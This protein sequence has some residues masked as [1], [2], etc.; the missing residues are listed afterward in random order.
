MD[1]WLKPKKEIALERKHPWIF[2]GALAH[3]HE[4]PEDGT[5]VR[6][7]DSKGNY[8]A[9]GHYHR[10]SIAVR[11]LSYQ[12]EN[13]SNIDFWKTAIQDAWDCRKLVGL[14]DGKST[15]SFRL[16]HGEGD[17]LSGLVVDVYGS[18][19][20]LQ[21]HSIGMYLQKELI[22]QA[23]METS[24]KRIE[25]IYDKSKEA[26][27]RAFSAGL[28]DG[29]IVGAG[30]GECTISENNHSFKINLETGQKTGFFLDQRDNRALLAKYAAGKS[31]LNTFCYTGGFSV[32]AFRAGASSVISVDVSSKAMLI[33]DENIKLNAAVA[34]NHISV[35][36]DAMS[37]FKENETLFDIVVVDPPAFAKSMNKRHNAVQGYKRLNAAAIKCI[38]PG[39][40]LFTFSCSQVVDRELFY[41]TITAAA[42][43]SGRSARVLHHMGQG[44]DHPVSLFHPEGH[45]LKG[46]VVRV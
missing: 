13:L 45:Y 23:I 36:Q 9:S 39:G 12:D 42:I 1:I 17:N 20:V 2:S 34:S 3:M 33:T 46:L 11:I 41:N 30:S 4:E 35:T 38:K 22:A 16:I 21:C 24:N 19:A 40:L 44:A 7:C 32:Y 18:T 8:I 25:N 37:F 27:P 28:E 31:V 26:L 14:L 6:V 15:N 29:Y 5:I 10:G 43:E